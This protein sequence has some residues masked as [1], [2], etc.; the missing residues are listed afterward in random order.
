MKQNEK[1]NDKLYII[2]KGKVC[3]LMKNMDIYER[4]NQKAKGICST[5]E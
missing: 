3:V 4:D 2:V 5:T 1:S